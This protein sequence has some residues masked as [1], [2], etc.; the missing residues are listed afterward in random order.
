MDD[1][2]RIELSKL[3]NEYNTEETTTKIRNLKHSKLIRN[4]V[5][6]IVETR[7]QF[8]R[9]AKN[10]IVLFKEMCV[11]RAN[12]LF[13]NYTN[14]FNKII[15]GELNLEIL[16][17]FIKILERIENGNIDQHDGSYEAGLL[18]KQM[19]ID[20]ALERND[21]EKDGKKV[22]FKKAIHKISWQDYKKSQ[23]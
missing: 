18:L 20:S 13:N 17:R 6:T 23:E 11:K 15:N 9:I 16:S 8:P 21:H 22:A 2:Q 12:F 4:D 19:Y 5:S 10:N 1:N 7:N 14:L 3:L